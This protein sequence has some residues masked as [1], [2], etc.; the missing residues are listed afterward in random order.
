MKILWTRYV[1]AKSL[2]GSKYFRKATIKKTEGDGYEITGKEDWLRMIDTGYKNAFSNKNPKKGT[3][4]A[5]CKSIPLFPSERAI[6]RSLL[7]LIQNGKFPVITVF[8][9]R[10]PIFM[11]AAWYQTS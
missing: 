11:I 4:E 9:D 3:V 7:T 10:M 6:A 5:K 2:Y 8:N 1:E